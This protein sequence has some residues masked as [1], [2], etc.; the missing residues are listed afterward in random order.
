[1]KASKVLAIGALGLVAALLIAGAALAVGPNGTS[2]KAG[3]GMAAGG[4]CDRDH[5]RLH[6]GSCDGAMSPDRA[7]QSSWHGSG[8]Q[9]CDRTGD[10]ACGVGDQL[11]LRDGSCHAR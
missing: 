3:M 1:M 8:E 9:A 6:D 11:R 10:G 5:E 7:C 4:T 2:D